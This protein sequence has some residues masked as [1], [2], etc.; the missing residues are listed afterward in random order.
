M[1]G[2]FDTTTDRPSLLLAAMGD[3]DRKVF[4]GMARRKVFPKGMTIL[5]AG[6]P[7]AIMVL[8]ETGRVE[9]SVTSMAGRKSV[10]NHMGAGEVLGEIA[11]LDGGPRSAD[12]VAASEVTG[13]MLTRQHIMGFLSDRPDI[14]F[15]LIEV[16]CGKVR[17]ASDM[18]SSQSLTEGGQRLARGLLRLFRKWGEPIGGERLRLTETFSQTDIGEFAGLARENVNRYLKAWTA[19]G[20]LD[21]D[22]RRLILVNPDALAALAEI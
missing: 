1:Q 21:A 20:I 6:E 19:E 4:L 3:E 8:I 2:Y 15:A 12:A 16:L 13:L 7:G 10:L 17:N 22:G 18:Y 14:A 9:V 5:A 11:T